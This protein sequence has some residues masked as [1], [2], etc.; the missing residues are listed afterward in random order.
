MLIAGSGLLAWP[1]GWLVGLGFV[2]ILALD[3]CER[4][5]Y[6]KPTY[7][8]GAA[9]YGIESSSFAARRG[10]KREEDELGPRFRKTRQLLHCPIDRSRYVDMCCIWLLRDQEGGSP[11][12]FHVFQRILLL[13]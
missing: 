10:G 5:K 12:A 1:W 9:V 13:L 6:M 7:S 4:A 8:I 3:L 2:P 11:A